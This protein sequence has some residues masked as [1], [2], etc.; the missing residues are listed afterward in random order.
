MVISGD[1]PKSTLA[2]AAVL[3][4]VLAGLGAW[5]LTMVADMRAEMRASAERNNGQDLRIDGLERRVNRHDDD[6][7]E[8]QRARK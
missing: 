3:W 4:A 5:T 7:R 6:I 8:L 2:V 1:L